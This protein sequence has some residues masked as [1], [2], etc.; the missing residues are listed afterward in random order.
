VITVEERI[1][2]VTELFELHADSVFHVAWRIVWS[3]PDAEDVTQATFV[4]AFTRLD[5]LRE[6][7]RERPWLLQ[8]AYHG[9]LEVLRRRR[10]V[11]TDPHELPERPTSED[12]ERI[13]DRRATVALL[14][15]AI[16]ELPGSLRI[17]FVLRDVEGLSTHEVADTLGI[18][19]SAAK[20]RVAR[21]REQ[22]RM[23]LEGVL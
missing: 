11:P 10:D 16:D 12:T 20:M 1:E 5:Q 8:I 21:A 17:A 14:Q 7:G 15:S 2:R 6:P 19:E 23:A 4:R 9:A 18:G 22:L 3:A 13:A